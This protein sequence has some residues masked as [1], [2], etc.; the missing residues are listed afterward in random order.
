VRDRS[1]RKAAENLAFA[2]GTALAKPYAPRS[3]LSVGRKG[4][5][6]DPLFESPVVRKPGPDRCL[7]YCRNGSYQTRV[8]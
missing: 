4:N 1:A 8:F 3:V 6:A 7:F 5:E 2:N